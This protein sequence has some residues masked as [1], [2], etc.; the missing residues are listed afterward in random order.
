[1]QTA[2]VVYQTTAV[3]ISTNETGLQMTNMDNETVT[4]CEGCHQQ[5][6]SP[7]I[8][9]IVSGQNV[10][11]D[12]DHSHMEFVATSNKSDV[13]TIPPKATQSFPPLNVQTWN[14]FFA[15]PDAKG[16]LSV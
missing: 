9:R 15:T 7:G 10:Q 3:T 12:G 14:A 16:G 4:L 6:M 1:M 2:I 8:Y 5:T 11:V 13:P